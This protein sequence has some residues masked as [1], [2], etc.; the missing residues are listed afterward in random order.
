MVWEPHHTIAS[1]EAEK[2]RHA[3]ETIGVLLLEPFVSRTPLEHGSHP[4]FEDPLDALARL[5]RAL[6]VSDS[7]DLSSRHSTLHSLESILPS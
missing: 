2:F 7:P 6:D 4:L 5:G 1:L 3:R